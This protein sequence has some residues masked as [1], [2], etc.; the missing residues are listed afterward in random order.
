MKKKLTAHGMRLEA[1]ALEIP[2]FPEHPNRIP[3]SGVLTRLE[4]RKIA[5]EVTDAATAWLVSEGYDPAYGARPLKRAIQRRVLDPLA[6]RVLEGEI[7][8]G[9]KI[10][11]DVN[12]DGLTFEKAQTVAHSS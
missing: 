8:E 1:M 7:R 10:V 6:L 5:V 4:D 3:F 11:V 12:G 2:E 9:D